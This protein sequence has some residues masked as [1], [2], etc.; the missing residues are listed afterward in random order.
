MNLFQQVFQ[1]FPKKNF[2]NNLSKKKDDEV[3]N[4]ATELSRKL[5]NREE[6]KNVII[7][8]ALLNR[9]AANICLK[10]AIQSN[11]TQT[12]MD[13][14]NESPFD[15]FNFTLNHKDY[16]VRKTALKNLKNFLPENTFG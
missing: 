13:L 7:M 6:T 9:T 3:F 14:T 15:L 16:E 4:Q 12:Y 1:F 8:E 5:L 10:K 11:Q 2:V